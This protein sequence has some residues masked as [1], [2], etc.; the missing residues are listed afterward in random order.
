MTEEVKDYHDNFLKI[1]EQSLLEDKEILD[2]LKDKQKNFKS[3]L[4]QYNKITE[5][6][7]ELALF[8]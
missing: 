7:G 8:N 5:Q 1:L 6:V 3:F 4:V 2:F